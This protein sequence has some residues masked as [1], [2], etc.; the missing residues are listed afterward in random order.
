MHLNFAIA[1]QHNVE[2]IAYNVG[3]I[4]VVRHS[5]AVVVVII[6]LYMVSLLYYC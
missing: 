1:H 4:E 5:A 3:Q 2:I 6:L